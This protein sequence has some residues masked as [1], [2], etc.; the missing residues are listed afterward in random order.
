MIDSRLS[1]TLV[2]VLMRMV[3]MLR[4]RRLL[5]LLLLWQLLLLIMLQLLLVL[6]VLVVLVVV[7]LLLLLLVSGVFVVLHVLVHEVWSGAGSL[8][9]QVRSADWHDEPLQL[10]VGGATV[11]VRRLQ[12]TV[13]VV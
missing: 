5:L 1:P 2:V 13:I 12:S 8:E 4:L 11:H 9:S 10:P 7:V 3:L 6:R